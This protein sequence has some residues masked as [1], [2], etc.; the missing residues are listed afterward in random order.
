MTESIIIDPESD[1]KATWTLSPTAARRLTARVFS[2]TGQSKT[3]TSPTDGA[4]VADVPLSSTEDVQTAFARARVAQKAWSKRPLR[5]RAAIL[6]RLAEMIIDRQDEILDII[7]IETGKARVHAFEEVFDFASNCSWV[8]RTG[9]RVL[10]DKYH[11]GMTYVGT[12]VREILHPKGV[13]GMISP[14]NF[15]LVLTVSDAV[16]AWMAGNA[17]VL[18]PDSQTPLTA[19]WAAEIAAEAGLPEDLFVIVYGPG[20]TLGPEIIEQANYISFTGSTATGKTIAEQAARGFKGASLELGGKN[21]AYVAADADVDRAAEG[22]VRDCFGNSGQACVS[23]ER[24]YVHSS[25]Y[26]EFV[27]R[28]A[29]RTADVRLGIARDWSYDMG[30]LA[31]KSQLDTISEHLADAVAKGAKVVA[32]GSPRPEIGPFVM[33]PTVLVDVPQTAICYAEET[34]GPLVSVYRVDSDDEGIR[35]A[36]DSRYGLNATVWSGS[37]RNGRRLASQIE[38]GTVTV[39]DAFPISWAAFSSPMGGRKQSGIGRRHGRAGILRYTEP[40]TIAVQTIPLKGIYA[41]GGKFYRNLL[42][43]ATKASQKTRFPWP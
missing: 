32:G 19:L 13:I 6:R 10:R 24:I 34:F 9:P 22:L 27:R 31:S 16:P 4:P 41:R 36:N 26:D 21:P 18:K 8:A 1:P 20:A 12:P 38:A 35:L 14:W 5:E 39:N 43:T 29:Q 28:F 23:I 15:P 11:L 3:T 30:S 2:T 42:T 37:G 33:E 40:Q 7:Q 25:I 17:V